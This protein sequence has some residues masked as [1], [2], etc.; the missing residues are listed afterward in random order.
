MAYEYSRIKDNQ[1]VF[2]T[3]NDRE[4]YVGFEF[5]SQ[6][7]THSCSQCHKIYEIIVE[8]INDDNPPFDA[9]T[10]T[11]VMAIIQ[12]YTSNVSVGA[13][14][15]KCYDKDGK[16]CQREAHFERTFEN[17]ELTNFEFYSQTFEFD[18]TDDV[19]QVKY[20]LIASSSHENYCEIVSEFYEAPNY[21]VSDYDYEEE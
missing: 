17:S 12:E 6:Y 8:C 7:F 14:M 19:K 1:F 15:Y 4:Y 9:G 20:N 11:T 16:G 13:I 10:M 5:S 21:W 2:L 3:K 18:A